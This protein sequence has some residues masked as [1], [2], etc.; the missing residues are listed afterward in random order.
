MTGR[1]DSLMD[2]VESKLDQAHATGAFVGFTREEAEAA[3]AFTEDAIS[4]EDAIKAQFV[5]DD[6]NAPEIAET[7]ERSDKNG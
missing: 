2:A 3:G 7:A 5:A 4:A 1:N 6:P